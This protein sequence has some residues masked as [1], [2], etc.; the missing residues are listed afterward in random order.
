MSPVAISDRGLARLRAR[1]AQPLGVAIMDQSVI[2]G[3]GNVWKSELCFTLRLDPFAPVRAYDDAE[4]RALLSL[5]RTQMHDTVHA[6]RR[7][8]PDPFAS[9]AFRQ[10]RLDRRQGESVM[11]VY[12]REG[13]P[14][15]DCGGTIAMKRQGEQL[16]S[17]YYCPRCQPER[18][19]A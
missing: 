7:T 1:S 2:A 18:G 5:A 3:I 16:R 15:Y 4:L 9:R 17:T 13:K 6:P 10:T 12:E 14:C 11:S 8:L 19:A